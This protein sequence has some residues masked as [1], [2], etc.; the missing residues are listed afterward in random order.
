MKNK[1]KISINFYSKFKLDIEYSR[2]IQI[3]KENDFLLINS[4]QNNFLLFSKEDFVYKIDFG[5]V[6]S[7]QECVKEIS[8]Q[9]I[10]WVRISKR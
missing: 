7:I 10:E 4:I 2:V 5:G 6:F 1:Y 9:N 8:Q 3:L